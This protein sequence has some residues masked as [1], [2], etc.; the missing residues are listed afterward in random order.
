MEKHA[1]LDSIF[2]IHQFSAFESHIFLTP[3]P[4][5]QC[6]NKSPTLSLNLVKIDNI[7]DGLR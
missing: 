4:R 7:S 2:G 5:A 3:R 6:R 1:C